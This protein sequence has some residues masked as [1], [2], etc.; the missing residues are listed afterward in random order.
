MLLDSS[1]T[2]ISNGSEVVKLSEETAMG[3]VTVIADEP[4]T[5]DASLAVAIIKALPADTPVTVPPALTVATASLED[6]QV[7]ILFVALAGKTEPVAVVVE[8]IPIEA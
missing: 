7:K 8:P 4:V 5:P 6:D 1:P 2:R 3:E